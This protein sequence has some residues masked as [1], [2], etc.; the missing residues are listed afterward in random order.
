MCWGG[1]GRKRDAV[2]VA[3]GVE[4]SERDRVGRGEERGR[5][6]RGIGRGEILREEERRGREG[7]GLMEIGFCEMRSRYQNQ[8]SMVAKRT[9]HADY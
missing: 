3:K 7:E 8:V 4:R 9:E 1:G 2:E 5:N 6:G